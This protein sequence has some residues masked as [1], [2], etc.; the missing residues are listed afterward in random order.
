MSKIQVTEAYLD[1]ETTGLS[2]SYDEITVIGIY[3]TN[4]NDSRF[5]QLIGKDNLEY[6]GD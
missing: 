3:L 4:K 2:P 1:I 6:R 5:A